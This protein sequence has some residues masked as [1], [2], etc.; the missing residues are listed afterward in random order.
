ML[1]S[2]IAYF[3]TLPPSSATA[4]MNTLQTRYFILLL[5]RPCNKQKTF[6]KWSRQD[7]VFVLFYCFPFWFRCENRDRIFYF[8]SRFHYL[9]SRVHLI[10]LWQKIF[11]HDF[12]ILF[13]NPKI[14]ENT[15]C[16]KG[17]PF[18]R[19]LMICTQS[20][21]YPSPRSGKKHPFS[22]KSSNRDRKTFF[23]LFCYFFT[24]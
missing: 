20:I 6:N 10:K 3:T 7:M 24:R 1:L 5:L 17:K 15:S 21:L 9:L 18:Y 12:A 8:L 23:L 11:Y 16:K 4:Y 19:T 2:S 14:K 22:C 13:G